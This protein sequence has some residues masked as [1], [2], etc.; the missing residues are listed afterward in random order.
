MARNVRR[1]IS[2]DLGPFE[3]SSET[4]G[5][6]EVVVEGDSSNQIVENLGGGGNSFGQNS[7][8]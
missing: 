3:V 7:L 6:K 4:T 5:A 2:G 8:L 1:R